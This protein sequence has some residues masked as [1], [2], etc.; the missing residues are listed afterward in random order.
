M[1]SGTHER[2]GCGPRAD[3]GDGL[4]ADFPIDDYYEKSIWPIR[5]IEGI[6][7]D[8]IREFVGP[9]EGLRILEIGSGGGHVLAMFRRSKLTAADVSEKFLETAKRRLAGYD[10]E[11]VHG[12]VCRLDLPAASFDRIICTEVLEHTSDPD[13]ILA[14]AVRLLA[15]QGRAVIT[16]PNDPLIL[17]LKG[18]VRLTPVGWLLGDRIEWGGDRYHVHRWT[19]SEFEALLSRRFRVERRRFAPTALLPIRACFL[20]RKP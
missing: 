8:I 7:L 10:V 15:P 6:R 1:S 14:E 11:F 18:L 4:A 20:C 16:V 2:D 17:R 19:P 5:V 13:A 9:A 12:D 3:D